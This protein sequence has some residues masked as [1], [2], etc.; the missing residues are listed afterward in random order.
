M[1]AKVFSLMS[2]VNESRFL[3]GMNQVSVNVNWMKVYVI[4]RKNGIVIKLGGMIVVYIKIIICGILA[5][6]TV[7]VKNH[8]KLMNI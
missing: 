5:H 1:N 6:V 4:Q 7:I 2:G 3:L 8:V